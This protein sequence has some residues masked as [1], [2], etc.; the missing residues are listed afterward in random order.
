MD[1]YDL[2]QLPG[3]DEEL[4]KRLKEQGYDTL[5]EVAYE[6]CEA[7]ATDAEVTKDEAER[8][9]AAANRLLGLEEEEEEE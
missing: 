4:E 2:K 9:I 1:E 8:I 7:F 6:E 5:W 3:V